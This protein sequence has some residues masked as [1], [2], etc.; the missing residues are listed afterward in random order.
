MLAKF[1]SRISPNGDCVR[2]CLAC[3]LELPLVAVPDFTAL[4]SNPVEEVLVTRDKGEPDASY[5]RWYFSLQQFVAQ[6]GFVLIEIILSDRPWLPL[7]NEA[8]AI[9]M[10]PLESGEKH[11]IVGKV[12]DGRFIPVFDPMGKDCATF[13]AVES[14]AFLVPADPMTQVRMG[15]ALETILE[16]TRGISNRI[17]ADAINEECFAAL[18]KKPANAPSLIL[19]MDGRPT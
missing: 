8:F 9:F 12:K 10:G 11:A 4:E 14:V 15:K 5:D 19:G 2:A 18:G 16:L 13:T 6:F 3:L 7:P 17:V 1:Q